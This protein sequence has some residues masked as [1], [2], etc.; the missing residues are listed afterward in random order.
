MTHSGLKR[1]IETGVDLG[2]LGL[3]LSRGSR[4]CLALPNGPEAATCFLALATRCP[5]APINLDI[6]EGAARAQLAD[7]PAAAVVLCRGHG[8]ASDRLEALATTMGIPVVDL[9]PDRAGA[10]MFTLEVRAATPNGGG[11]GGGGDGGGA[12]VD[13]GVAETVPPP[14]ADGIAGAP[15]SGSMMRACCSTRAAPRNGPRGSRSPSGAC[16]APHSAS[17]RRCSSPT[18]NMAG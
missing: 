7:L 16:A 5:V 17:P 12:N 3:G 6:S 11:G 10:G 14:P 13:A 2:L 1:F 4:I 9:V 8:P 15:L 18:A